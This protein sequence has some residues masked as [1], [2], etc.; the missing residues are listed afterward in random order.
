ML[1]LDGVAAATM[2][3]KKYEKMKDRAE[4]AEAELLQK[5]QQL[6]EIDKLMRRREDHN[7]NLMSE[8]A[9][10]K[11]RV[12]WRKWPEEKPERAGK[13]VVRHMDGTIPGYFCKSLFIYEGEPTYWDAQGVTHWLP[14][15]ELED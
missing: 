1:D 4:K 7:C 3:A 10:L 11:E 15:P 5:T 12:R 2:Y 13:Y 8:N 9:T 6:A 14:I